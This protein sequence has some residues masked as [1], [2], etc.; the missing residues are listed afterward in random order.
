MRRRS[1]RSPRA[2][3]R[4][5]RAPRGEPRA[6]EERS[7]LVHEDTLEQA[8]L[9]CGSQSADG[10]AVAAGC[11]A[12]RIAVR[13]GSRAPGAKSS[14]AWRDIARQR[15]TSSSCSARARAGVG[16]SRSWSSAQKRIDPP[17]RPRRG[18]HRLCGREVVAAKRGERHPVGG[19]DTDRRRRRG[20]RRSRSPRPARAPWAQESSTS[21]SGRRRWSSRTTRG[22]GPSSRRT[23]ASGDR[24]FVTTV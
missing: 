10:R 3:C 18:E 23:I 22:G 17:C 2:E 5:S 12:A 4:R 15:S 6:L 20:R 1:L 21:S 11:E 9:E 8:L 14:A 16:S 19:G 7:R 24:S 13:E